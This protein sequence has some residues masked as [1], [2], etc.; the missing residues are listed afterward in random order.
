MKYWLPYLTRRQTFGLLCL[1]LLVQI[2]ESFPQ[3]SRDSLI[4]SG[5]RDIYNINFESA[6]RKFRTL[7]ASE[8]DEPAGRFFLAMIDWWKIL[9]DTEDRQ[10][11]DLFYEKLEDI[12]HHCDKLLDKRPKD[13]E[14]LFFKGGAI[15]FRARLRS[16]REDWINAADDGRIALP[17]VQYVERND[18][19]NTDVL[20]GT[21]IYNY[22]ASV[23][24]EKYPFIKPL[25]LFFPSGDKKLGIEQLKKTAE[26]GKY[27]RYEAMYLLLTLHYAFENDMVTAME[28]AR[29]LHEE[30]PDN[31]VFE[32]WL[33]RIGVRGGD[34]DLYYS[35]FSGVIAKGEKGMRG[36][37]L[38]ARREAHYYV[39]LYHQ[40]WRN[41]DSTIAHFKKCSE[42][43]EKLDVDDASGYWVNAALY[44]GMEYDRRQEYGL[45]RQYYQKVLDMKEYGD[46]HDLAEKYLEFIKEK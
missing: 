1:L 43:S 6:E 25:M 28:Y 23:I 39:G 31:P 7:M 11:D 36:Y 5:I 14:A 42:L 17:I 18:P 38:R 20:L 24:P 30:F 8:P 27:S 21:G 44:L 10:H 13:I 41:S 34:P 3:S 9:L 19:G 46:S 4:H 33:G 45:A 22:Y 29:K 37:T 40:A 2:G 32:K 12:I 16:L 35:I 26:T 15:G